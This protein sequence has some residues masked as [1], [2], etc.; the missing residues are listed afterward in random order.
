[1]KSVLS[2]GKESLIHSRLPPR[3]SNGKPNATERRPSG[4]TPSDFVQSQTRL[5]AFRTGDDG[6]SLRHYTIP[7]PR[8]LLQNQQRHPSRL[9]PQGRKSAGMS[10]APAEAERNTRN[11]AAVWHNE[12]HGSR[13]RVFGESVDDR[14]C[15]P[16]ESRETR[17]PGGIQPAL[18]ALDGRCFRLG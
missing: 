17:I 7:T 1:M 11:V 6:K 15:M 13:C 9:P 12:A 14:D 2:S 5:K 10:P 8:T 16:W 4:N 3:N 18:I